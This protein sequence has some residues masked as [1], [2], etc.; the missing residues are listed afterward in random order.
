MTKRTDA[1]RQ[2]AGALAL[3]ALLAG[4][5]VP[6]TVPA[7]TAD[8]HQH[9]F[10]PAMAALLDDAA[11]PFAPLDADQLVALLDAAGVTRA[12]L[13]STGY[14]AGAPARQLA[15]AAARIRAENEWTAAQAARY[16]GRLVAFCGLNPLRDDALAELERCAADPRTR[17]GIKL[18]FAN[19]DV[20]LDDADHV[21]RVA[22]VFAAANAR[23]M[24][25]VV[26][27]RASIA[28]QRPYGA[29]QARIFLERIL[30]S[31]PDVD[32]QVAHFAGSG[33]GY[34]D[35]G[36]QAAMDVL[37]AA[38]EQDAPAARRLW[39]D[40]ASIVDADIPAS[41]A[42]LVVRLVRRVGP[43]RVLFGSDAAVGANLRPRAAWAAFCRLPLRADELAVIA[44]NVAPYLRPPTR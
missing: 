3:V 5:A 13:L 33:P 38:V 8:H 15:D 7:P 11:A 34:D 18:H 27:L 12:V 40:V 37:A 22:A 14:I 23:R 30:P 19:S 28:R 39:F 29:A 20:R 24:A 25:I 43:H 1:A 32:V 21:A 4:C 6:R 9:L 35:S 26:H 2:V 10:S 36:A 44:G 41:T 42:E 31:A 16:P 17:G